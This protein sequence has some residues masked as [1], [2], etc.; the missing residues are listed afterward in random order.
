M[1]IPTFCLSF[2]HQCALG[3]LPCFGC[4]EYASLNMSVHI[5]VQVLAFSYLGR[6]P[7]SGLLDHMTVLCL[8]FEGTALLFSLCLYCTI[9]NFH[10]QYSHFSTSLPILLI[11][12]FFFFFF[13]LITALV[14]SKY[15]VV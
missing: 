11:F 9:L 4:C 13:F 14:F 1:F 7:R 15:E 8:T 3:L 5:S 6:I 12:F 10:K 2:I